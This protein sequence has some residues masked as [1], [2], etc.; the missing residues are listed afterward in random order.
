MDHILEGAERQHDWE[1]DLH[2]KVSVISDN[3]PVRKI[4]CR[5]GRGCTH[6]YDPVHKERFWH[7]SCPVLNGTM[8]YIL[9]FECYYLFLR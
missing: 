7:P 2:P 3:K 4:I 6:M 5:Y 1:E 8:S 9:D